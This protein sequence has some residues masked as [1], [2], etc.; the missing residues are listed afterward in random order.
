[1]LVQLGL[2]GHVAESDAG[3]LDQID[4][5]FLSGVEEV[6]EWLYHFRI[7]FEVLDVLARSGLPLHEIFVGT[8]VGKGYSRVFNDVF[9]QVVFNRFE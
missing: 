3:G 4:F 2:G 9:I 5:L 1:M 6:D 7:V 8:E